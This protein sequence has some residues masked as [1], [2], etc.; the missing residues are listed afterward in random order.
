MVAA[1][2]HRRSL[3]NSL[4]SSLLLVPFGFPFGGLHHTDDGQR[5]R[6]GAVVEVH[7]VVT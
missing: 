3:W 5:T 1:A 2:A 7:A 6:F 4:E